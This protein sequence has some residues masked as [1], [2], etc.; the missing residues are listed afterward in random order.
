MRCHKKSTTFSLASI[1]T[2]PDKLGT[3]SKKFFDHRLSKKG[4]GKENVDTGK[5]IKDIAARI[6]REY[7]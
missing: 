1:L 4:K 6:K 5:K 3:D 2:I 7:R